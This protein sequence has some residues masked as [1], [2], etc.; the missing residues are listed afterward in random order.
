MA[1]ASAPI[2][3]SRDSDKHCIEKVAKRSRPAA[4]RPHPFEGH[5]VLDQIIRNIKG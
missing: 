4:I 3:Q 5:P 2:G 1:D